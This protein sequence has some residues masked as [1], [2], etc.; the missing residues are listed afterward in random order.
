MVKSNQKIPYTEEIYDKYRA[1]GKIHQQIME[2]ARDKI[3]IGMSLYDYACFIDNRI[4]ELGGKSA[5][6]VNISINEEAAHD[7]AVLNDS[8]I[9]GED[10][11][12]VDVGVHIDGYIA[13]GAMTIDL[14]GKQTALVKASEEALKAA[15]DIIKAGTNTFEIGAAI[16][17]TIVGLGFQPVRNLMGH[18]V[19][20]Y[21]AH[22]EPSVPNCRF[23]HGTAELRAGE[24]I[25]IEPFATDGEGYVDNGHIKEIY[26]Q[27][28]RKSTRLPQ[29]RKV[30]TQIEEYKGLPFA[31]RW[32]GSDKIEFA[33]N[34]LEKENILISYPVLVEVSGGLV[35][36]AEHTVIV[37]ENGCEVTTRG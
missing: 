6:P 30:L 37:T 35:S 28:Q 23:T 8:R 22:T 4:I 15:I 25:A 10:V 3:K 34:Q 29:V 2:E 17:D 19:S 13:D 20:Q 9:F 27:K 24:T 1:A 11:V 12:K 7:T 36:Q 26:S 14:S 16:E 33:L 21:M 31:K 5:F 18:G 32:L